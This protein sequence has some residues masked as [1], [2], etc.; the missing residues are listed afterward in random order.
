MFFVSVAGLTVSRLE[1]VALVE[2]RGVNGQRDFDTS[3]IVINNQSPQ[4]ISF[5]ANSVQKL[6][7]LQALF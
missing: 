7:G 6:R 2:N 1:I 3:L 4:A 5:G